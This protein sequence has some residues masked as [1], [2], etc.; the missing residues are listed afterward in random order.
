MLYRVTRY[1]VN[2]RL[3]TV[4]LQFLWARGQDYSFHTAQASS[5]LR[6]QL[7]EKQSPNV[8]PRGAVSPCSC[9]GCIKSNCSRKT[10]L[11]RSGACVTERPTIRQPSGS[12]LLLVII[13]KRAQSRQGRTKLVGNSSSGRNAFLIGPLTP[14]IKVRAG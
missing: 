8:G 7:P 14:H 9:V 12:V 10:N 13:G 4:S 5:I 6:K 3:V 2:L 11:V 1:L